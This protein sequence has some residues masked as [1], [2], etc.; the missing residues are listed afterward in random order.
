MLNLIICLFF[1]CIICVIIGLIK[2]KFVICWGDDKFKTRKKVLKYYG[3]G[4]IIIFILIGIWAPDVEVKQPEKEQE[5]QEVITTEKKQEN[6]EITHKNDEENNENEIETT[7]LYEKIFVAFSDKIGTSNFEND[8]KIIDSMGYSAKIVVPTEED[9]GEITV[10]DSNGNCV[11]LMYYPNNS[12]IETL[13]L[14]SY[15]KHDSEIYISIS[16]QMHTTKVKYTTY[17]IDS[18]PRNKDVAGLNDLKRFMFVDM[19]DVKSD[20]STE[21]INVYMNV[22]TNVDSKGVYFDIDTNLPDETKLMLTL[23][24]G[25]QYRG[26]ANVAIKSGKCKSDSFT[27][28]GNKLRGEYTLEISMP[29]ATVQPDSVRKLIGNKGENLSGDLVVSG[30]LEGEKMIK[31]IINISL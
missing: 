19:K 1:I 18:N 8:Q 14:I 27:N 22:S 28:K 25:N 24:D 4:S 10:K 31:K 21:E 30:T 9:L 5:S 17:N 16:N 26:Q 13:T 3:I 23:S 29:I 6:K 12:K 15:K 7:E 11:T 20:T 2:P